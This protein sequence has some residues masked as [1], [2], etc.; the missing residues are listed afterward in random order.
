MSK[1]DKFL[2]IDEGHKKNKKKEKLIL[3]DLNDQS[4]RFTTRRK[5]E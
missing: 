5:G 4:S 3:E 1:S 2:K